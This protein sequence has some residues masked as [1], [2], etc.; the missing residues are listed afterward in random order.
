MTASVKPAPLYSPMNYDSRWMLPCHAYLSLVITIPNVTIIAEN[1]H[2]LLLCH[3]SDLSADTSIICL[4]FYSF[5]FVAISNWHTHTVSTRH[6]ATERDFIS[7]NREGVKSGLV[8]AKELHQYRATHDIRRQPATREGFRRSAP[9][10]MTPDA[11]LGV[12]NR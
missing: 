1:K 4:L 7:L 2:N 10:R 3:C 9:P 6:R 5:S 12:T 11:S 8:T